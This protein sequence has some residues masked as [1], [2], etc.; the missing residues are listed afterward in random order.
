LGLLFS[1]LSFSILLGCTPKTTAYNVEPPGAPKTGTTRV[2]EAGAK[3]LQTNSPL[4]PMDVYLVGFHAMKDDPRHQMEAHHFCHQVN[5]DFAQCVIFDGNTTTANLTGIEYIISETLFERLPEG[6]RKYWHPHNYE[7]LSGTLTAP[8]IPAIAEKK[9]M[10]S[11]MNSYGKTWHVWSTAGVAAHSDML[12]F[13]DAMLAWSF[14]RDGEAAPRLVERAEERMGIKTG[15]KRRERG[16]LF[17]LAHAQEGVDALKGK[18]GRTTADIPG[19][20]DK[21]RASSSPAAT[22]RSPL[23]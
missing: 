6:E 5:E 20:V 19:V 8:G 22:P 2:L 11:K 12:P 7:I 13:G 18:F 14:N 4:G 23:R 1:V 15:E 3:V 10:E 21:E 17:P 9:L 16:D